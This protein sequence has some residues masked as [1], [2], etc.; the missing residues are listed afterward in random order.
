MCEMM[1]NEVM[2]YGEDEEQ[3][4]MFE[5]DLQQFVNRFRQLD[6][7]WSWEDSADNSHKLCRSMSV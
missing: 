6:G 1:W 5:Q 3:G 2:I 7:E 4:R